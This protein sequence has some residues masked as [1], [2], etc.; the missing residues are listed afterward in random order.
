VHFPPIGAFQAEAGAE[1]IG[2][3]A[4]SA[5]PLKSLLEQVKGNRTLVFGLEV[6]ELLQ[7]FQGPFRQFTAILLV[8]TLSEFLVV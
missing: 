1:L 2:R 6:F 7:C 5:A 4:V 3:G 8:E